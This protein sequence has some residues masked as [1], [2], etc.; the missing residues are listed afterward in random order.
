MTKK[1]ETEKKVAE[2]K[3]QEIQVTG[4]AEA[5]LAKLLVNRRNFQIQMQKLEMIKR[6]AANKNFKVFG[7]TKDNLIAMLAANKLGLSIDMNK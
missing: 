6:L 4:A 7:N 5:K 2:Y 3:A 1:A